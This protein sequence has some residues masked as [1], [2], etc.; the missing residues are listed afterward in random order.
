MLTKKQKKKTKE[1]LEKRN[2]EKYESYN[3]VQSLLKNYNDPNFKPILV[4]P[5]KKKKN[6]KL[7]SVQRSSKGELKISKILKILEINF[8]S[9]HI[10]E[11]CINP[12]TKCPLRFDFYLPT[13]NTCIEFDGIQH[14]EYTPEFHGLDP[15]KGA[16]KL[17]SQKYRDNIKDEF[18]SNRNLKLL[19]IKYSEFRK[20]EE[21]I[22]N[23]L[24]A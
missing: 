7:S 6:K 8:K 14:F 15:V 4:K 18:C 9:E 2:K 23:Y 22:K 24:S 5:S 21:I 1:L 12:R 16:S 13:H 11:D 19:R 3:K 17:K 10:F 20:I